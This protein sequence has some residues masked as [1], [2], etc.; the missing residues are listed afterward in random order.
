M[1]DSD[2][3]AVRDLWREINRSPV[4]VAGVMA[5]TARIAALCLRTL[6]DRASDDAVVLLQGLAPALRADAYGFDDQIGPPLPGS[7]FFDE[8]EPPSAAFLAEELA[9]ETNR[10]S[11]VAER[12]RESEV[13][14]SAAERRRLFWLVTETQDALDT[15]ASDLRERRPASLSCPTRCHFAVM[16]ART[17]EGPIP[18][19]RP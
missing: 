17:A 8:R 9:G 2:E 4:E 3:A 11:L 16:R 10:L 18:K 15:F 6:A 5:M 19:D 12:Y 7:A 1:T 14:A 13:D